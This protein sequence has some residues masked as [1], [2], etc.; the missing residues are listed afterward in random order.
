MEQ[1]AAVIT[2]AVCFAWL[3]AARSWRSPSS[4]RR[5]SSARRAEDAFVDEQPVQRTE[6][7]APVSAGSRGAG[8]PG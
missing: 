6:G 5:S 1:I 3:G 2:T 4:R 7:K 8:R